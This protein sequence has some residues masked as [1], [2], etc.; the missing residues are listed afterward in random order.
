MGDQLAIN[1]GLRL[2]RSSH[3]QVE[4]SKLQMLKYSLAGF[5]EHR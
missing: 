4:L 1:D 5:F 2:F 3:F